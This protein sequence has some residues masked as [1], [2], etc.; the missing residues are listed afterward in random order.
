M[1]PSYPSPPIST[2]TPFR[3]RADARGDLPYWGQQLGIGTPQPSIFVAPFATYSD[4]PDFLDFR[5]FAAKLYNTVCRCFGQWGWLEII[6]SA[7]APR[8]YTL[9]ADISVSCELLTVML[10][11]SSQ[12]FGNRHVFD[13]DMVRI[14]KGMPRDPYNDDFIEEVAIDIFFQAKAFIFKSEENIG[15]KNSWTSNDSRQCSLWSHLLC[16]KMTKDFNFRARRLARRATELDEDNARAWVMCAQTYVHG[17]EYGWDDNIAFAKE[18]LNRYALMA[19]NRDMRDVLCNSVMASHLLYNEDI[20]EAIR[21]M[22]RAIGYGHIFPTPVYY[23]GLMHSYKGELKEAIPI[24]LRAEQ[25]SQSDPARA[26]CLQFLGQ[27]Y[28]LQGRLDEGLEASLK[29]VRIN[30][31]SAPA[32]RTLAVNYAFRGDLVNGRTEFATAEESSPLFSIGVFHH[33]QRWQS[34]ILARIGEYT[35]QMVLCGALR[36]LPSG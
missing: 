15:I 14:I 25:R 1:T 21:R 17:V 30:P 29:A 22:E 9:E 6:N 19:F 26:S 10:K 24:L 27:A 31:L 33:A 35:E 2:V 18:A 16:I 32:R 3:R 8:R 13:D 5:S 11:P 28:C 4:S 36:D 34:P 20:N 12:Y 23:Y 7:A